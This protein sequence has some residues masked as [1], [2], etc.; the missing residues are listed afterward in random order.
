MSELNRIY[1]AV[2]EKMQKSIES[3][4]RDLLKIRTGKANINLLEDIKVDYYGQPT[5]IN[6]VGTLTIPEARIILIR[7]WEKTLLPLIEK[8]ILASDLGITPQNDGNVIRLVFPSLTEER[9]KDLVKNVKKHSE[10]AKIAIRNSRRHFNEEVKQL[11]KDSK[12]SEDVYQ[13]GLDEIQD[14]TDEFVEK[15]TNIIQNKEKEIMEI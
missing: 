8:A 15:I 11:E 6:H 10:E 4:K 2:K 12:I 3:L 1:K 13:D 9:R 14:I 7:P 5:P